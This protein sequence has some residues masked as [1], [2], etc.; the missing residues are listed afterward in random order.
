MTN[1]DRFAF[2]KHDETEVQSVLRLIGEL[3]PDAQRRISVVATILRDLL[4]ADDRQEVELAF[5]LVM[6]E[7][8]A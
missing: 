5:T 2:R 4:K 1:D 6:A 8:A 3:P 7:L